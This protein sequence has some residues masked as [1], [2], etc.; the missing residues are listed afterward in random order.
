MAIKHAFPSLFWISYDQEA[1]VA[2]LFGSSSGSLWW[3]FHF[4]RAV[5]DWELGD[6]SDH[7]SLLNTSRTSSMEV[8]R[9]FWTHSRNNIFKVRSLYKHMSC[10]NHNPFPWKR[11]WRSKVPPMV[12]FFGWTASND[13]FFTIDNMRKVRTH[14]CGLVQ[15]V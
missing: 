5:Q 14:C 13:F 9:L 3:N 15:Y 4:L 10:Q 6:I 11:I 12:A 7:F 8:E 2:D 1:S